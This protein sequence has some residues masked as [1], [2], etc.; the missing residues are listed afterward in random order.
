MHPRKD[1]KHMHTLIGIF[2]SGAGSVA[3]VGAGAGSGACSGA[4]SDAN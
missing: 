2:G 1:L 4:D 3:G